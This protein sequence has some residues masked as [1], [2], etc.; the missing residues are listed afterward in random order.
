MR[1]GVFVFDAHFTKLCAKLL[2]YFAQRIVFERRSS[3][4]HWSC[5]L[6]RFFGR[7]GFGK[8]RRKLANSELI[9][10][11]GQLREKLI[12]GKRRLGRLFR[13]GRRRRG[14]G[15]GLLMRRHGGL[16]IEHQLVFL[17]QFKFR[18]RFRSGS[19]IPGASR[20]AIFPG[21]LGRSRFNHAGDLCGNLG[22]WISGV[23]SLCDRLLGLLSG[24]KF[25]GN[26]EFSVCRRLR[27][28]RRS[29][30]SSGRLLR[31]SLFARRR[32]FR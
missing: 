12:G 6:R 3:F 11:T 2:E 7:F 25:E 20:L 23:G 19:L 22:E 27:G 18:F 26:L 30:L 13:L 15:A 8:L 4:R 29:W 16:R 9:N 32:R 28:R 31:R 14:N 21:A 10:F 24:R 17:I 1:F 5:G